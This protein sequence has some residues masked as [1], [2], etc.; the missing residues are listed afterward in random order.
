MDETATEEPLHDP[1]VPDEA[2]AALRA[3]MQQHAAGE[4]DAALAGAHEIMRRWPRYAQARSY[5]GQTLVTRK[6][7]FADGLAQLDRAVRDCHQDDGRADPYILYTAGW[8]QEFVAN[9]LSKEAGHHRPKGGPHQ[10]VEQS[11]DNLYASATALFLR[12]LKEDPDEQLLGDIEDM[13]TVIANVTGE[14]WD[15]GEEVER[16]IPRPR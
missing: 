3:V 5:V 7:Q 8:C 11:A 14:P 12:A 15:D 9:A 13:L 2:R 10:P 1:D 4:V 6:R 16:A